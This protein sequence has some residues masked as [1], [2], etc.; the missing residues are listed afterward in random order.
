M[1]PVCFQL[2]GLTIH[3]YGVLMAGGFLA[4]LLSW[5]LVGRRENR[6]PAYCSDLLFWVILSGIAGARMAYVLANLETF[7]ANPVS[8]FF[9]NEGGLI[10]YGGFLG[11]LAAVAVFAKTHGESVLSLYDFAVTSVPLAHAF[12][13]VGCLM[14]GCCFGRVCEGFPG[15]RFPAD[16]LPWYYH[17]VRGQIG[18]GARHSL[19]VH[20]V[21]LYEAALNLVLYVI[22]LVVYH[23]RRRAGVAA[24]TYLLLYPVVRFSLEFWRGDDRMHLF[25]LTVAQALSLAFLAGGGILML[26]VLRRD[27]PAM[28]PSPPGGK[29]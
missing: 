28:P 26:G 20:P 7:L 25:G 24:A 16:S 13:R 29:G 12:G 9:I 4:G 19:P 18:A 1:N 6:P 2:G 21:Q 23:R 3:W 22:L 8:V 27:E 5:M 15:V 10:F 11:G 17:T 14:N